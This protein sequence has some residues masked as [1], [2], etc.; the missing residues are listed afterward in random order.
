MRYVKSF[1]AFIAF[2]ILL[3]KVNAQKI[4]QRDEEINNI[5]SQ[6]SKDSLRSYVH[7]LVNFNTRSTLSSQ[8][9]KTKGIG[10]AR[11]WVLN[12]FKLYAEQSNGRMTAYIDTTTLQPDSKRVNRNI[13]LGNVVAILKGTDTADKRIFL[14]SGHLDSRRTDVMDSV[15]FA[16]GANDDGSGVAAVIEAARVLSS[17]S[18]PAT[19]IL[20][21]VSGEEQGLFGSELMANNAVKNHLQIE[22]VLNNDIIGS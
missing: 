14:M 12:K 21:A 16:P 19:I 11:N 15:N 3:N 17:H 22:A 7:Q 1:A 6:V 18:F 10:A 4:I 13:L 20:M 9:D 8:T 5:I 2:T